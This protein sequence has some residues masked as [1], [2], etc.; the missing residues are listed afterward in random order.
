MTGS[1]GPAGVVSVSTALSGKESA[2]MSGEEA[3]QHGR[4]MAGGASFFGGGSFFN[5]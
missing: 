3:M 1:E 2:P 4:K 5:T